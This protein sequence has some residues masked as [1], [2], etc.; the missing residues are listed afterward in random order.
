VEIGSVAP[1]VLLMA[2]RSPHTNR[3]DLVGDG[4]GGPAAKPK[5][6]TPSAWKNSAALAVSARFGVHR[7][8]VGLCAPASWRTAPPVSCGRWRA[9]HDVRQAARMTVPASNGWRGGNDGDGEARRLGGRRG[10]ARTAFAEPS[11]FLGPESS[12]LPRRGLRVGSPRAPLQL[13]PRLEATMIWG[14]ERQESQQQK[15]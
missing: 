9:D 13:Y 15:I 8:R 1:R 14:P 5:A 12:K 3:P 7:D 4:S 11:A 2:R 10:S 6:I